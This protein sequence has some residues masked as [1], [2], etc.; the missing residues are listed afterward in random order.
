MRQKILLIFIL[1]LMTKD[2]IM[3]KNI[4]IFQE[5][6]VIS[7]QIRNRKNHVV[8]LPHESNFNEKT[9]PIKA[10]PIQINQEL[11][12]KELLRNSKSPWSCSIFYVQKSAEL[13]R[14]T[15]RLVLNYKPLNRLDN[16]GLRVRFVST[17][18]TRL[19]NRVQHELDPIINRVEFLNP[20]TTRV[21]REEE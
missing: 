3:L 18:T 13:E 7:K 11:L 8:K 20:N 12:Q 19:Y 17:R 15:P 5:I 14:G 6:N 1:P 9:I 10:R 21:T 2:I 16:S 4:S